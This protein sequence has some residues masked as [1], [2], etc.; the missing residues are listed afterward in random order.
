[1]LLKGSKYFG[2][3]CFSLHD[4]SKMM[5]NN[6]VHTVLD[7]LLLASNFIRI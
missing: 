5:N 7:C 3:Y 6:Y 1:M 2:F 4:M